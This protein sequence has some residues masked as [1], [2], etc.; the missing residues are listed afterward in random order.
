MTH[1]P[2][3]CK[4]E[5]N[6]DLWSSGMVFDYGRGGKGS[7]LMRGVK[8]FSFTHYCLRLDT[9]IFINPAECSIISNANNM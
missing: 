8:Y 3:N 5:G 6:C 2:F 7:I 1:R 9:L 4:R